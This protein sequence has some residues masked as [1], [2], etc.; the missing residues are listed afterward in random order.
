MSWRIAL[1]VL[2]ATPT[3]GFVPAGLHARGAPL[4]STDAPETESMDLD[5]DQ[6]QELFSA[7]AD[8]DESEVLED[9]LELS[10]NKKRRKALPVLNGWQADMGKFCY[11]LP[12]AV[13]PM[14]D[15]DPLGFAQKGVPLNDVRRYREAEIMH[16]RVAMFAAVGYLAGEAASPVVWN[17]AVT[18]PANDQLAQIP[19]W[20]FSF[21]TL[22]IGVAET[23]RARVGW[24]SPTNPD[25]LFELKDDY[26]PGDIGFDPLGLKPKD[27]AEFAEMA[28]KELQNGRLAMIGVSGMCAQE[29][30]NHKTIAETFD[31]YSKVY[32]GIDPYQ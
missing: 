11:G 17:G 18:G 14:G 10:N 32:S 21:L 20:A 29:L 4:R 31:F 26:Y 24:V 22:C 1:V 23:Y 9:I 5:L 3:T 13:A 25:A 15:F 8:A 19:S 7:A 30:V 28:T 16:G 2:T 12:G 6:M 27:A